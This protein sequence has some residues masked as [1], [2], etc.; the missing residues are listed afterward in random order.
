MIPVESKFFNAILKYHPEPFDWANNNCGQ[1]V[2]KVYGD[3]LERDFVSGLS[4]SYTDKLSA[5]HFLH[6]QGGWD[7]ILTNLG[8]VRR[9]EGKLVRGDVVVVE[10]ALGLWVGDK[11]LYAGGAYKKRNEVTAAYYLEN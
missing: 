4:G 7:G 8:F 11:A 3:V 1:F 2:G 5:F 9:P 10:N 6:E